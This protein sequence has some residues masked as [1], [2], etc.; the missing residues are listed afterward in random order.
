[1]KKIPLTQGKSALVDDVDYDFLNQY[2]WYVLKE[3]YT[4][5]AGRKVTISPCKQE[6]IIMH[7][8]I[9]NAP[10]GIEIDHI[11]GDGLDNRRS[12]LRLCTRSQNVRCQQLNRQNTT[13]FKGV[14]LLKRNV[15]KPYYAQICVDRKRI[16]LSCH[17]TAKAA[18]RAY[19]LAALKYH[20]EFALTNKMLGLL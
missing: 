18:A 7:R 8:I 16:C 4:Y 3:D 11:N 1:M 19:D 5:Y 14:T 2:K 17:G 12:N 6:L 13:G 9:L 20:G 15:Q 10:N